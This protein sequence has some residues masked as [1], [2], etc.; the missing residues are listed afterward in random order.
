MGV[1]AHVCVRAYVC[2]GRQGAKEGRAS[3]GSGE[4]KRTWDL[5]PW[6]AWLDGVRAPAVGGRHPGKLAGAR[7]Q[8]YLMASKGLNFLP[9]LLLNPSKQ[10]SDIIRF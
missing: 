7:T 8:R 10:G 6:S 5:L 9:E 1:C 3:Q 4:R 2:L